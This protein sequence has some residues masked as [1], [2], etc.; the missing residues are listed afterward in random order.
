MGKKSKNEGIYVLNPKGNQPW[1]F[2]GRTDAEAKVPILWPPDTRS[3]LIGK[4]PD[5]GKD[6]E[7]EEKGMTED[8]MVGWHHWLN[9]HGF[10]PTPGDSEGQRSLACCGSWGCRESDTTQPLN[11]NN[12]EQTS[13]MMLRTV[14]SG[15]GSLGFLLWIYNTSLLVWDVLLNAK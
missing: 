1:I 14:F 3:W 9:G 12:N 8:E 11:D 15:C 13:W 7:Q 6:W 5:A 2:T 4:D 10:E